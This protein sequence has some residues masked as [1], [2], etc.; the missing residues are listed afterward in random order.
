MTDP[1]GRPHVER[2]HVDPLTGEV[3][4]NP[5]IRPFADVLRELS[6]G[7]THDE[8]GEAVYDLA[9]RVRAT[10]KKGTLTLTIA[11][12][13]MKGDEQVLVISDEIRLKLPEFPRK[14]S[15]F[16][17]TREGNLSRTNPQQLALDVGLRE[18]PNP[19]TNTTPLK[20][21]R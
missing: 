9:A 3:I 10:G 13:P 19:D 2:R 7:R 11:V 17:A 12:E 1:I 8:L 5:T 18:V 21:A 15:I 20:D 16:Y 6:Q 14:P 4:D